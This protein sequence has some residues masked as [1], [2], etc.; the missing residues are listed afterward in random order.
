MNQ[1]TRPKLSI[2]IPIHNE[3]DNLV[4]HHDKISKHLHDSMSTEI[5][6]VDDGSTDDS[7]SIIKSIAANDMSTHYI[8]LSRN[9]GKEAATTAGLRKATG[10][11]AILM[12]GDGQHPVEL[13]KNF[14]KEWRDGNQMV[15]GIRE[16]SKG[17]GAVKHFG[18]KLFYRFLRVLGSNE[19]TQPGLTDFRLIDRVIID[20]YNTLTEHNR[21]TRNLLDWLGYKRKLIPFN[22]NER[23]AG[24]AT[25][26][27]KKLTKLALDGIVKHSTRPLK[28]IGL[29]GGIISLFSAAFT[30]FVLVEQYV[31]RDPLGLGISGT[32]VLALFLSFMIGIVLF[33]QGLLALYLENVYYETQNRPLFVIKEEG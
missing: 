15:V 19:S 5:I 11:A 30:G 27:L 1:I 7:L 12:D 21:I 4:W 26:S 2:V 24:T 22:A 31:F 18:S 28:F 17:E 23:H 33:C 20:Q 13:V 6:Y 10:D 32:F 8:S 16:N 14:V 3:A 9:F 25:Y 29:L